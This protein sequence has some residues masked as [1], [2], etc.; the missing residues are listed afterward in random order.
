VPDL[1]ATRVGY[2]PYDHADAGV[3]DGVELISPILLFAARES[4]KEEFK[5]LDKLLKRGYFIRTDQSCGA[6]VHT[7]PRE[8]WQ[9]AHVK[10]LA[11]AVLYFEKTIDSLHAPHRSGSE[12]T[13]CMSN[14]ESTRTSPQDP[15]DRTRVIR[16]RD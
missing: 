14:R 9:L 3:I 13:Y 2:C 1:E 6:H 12:A 10:N 16:A 8:G 4:W 5:V 11:A 15:Q 7:S